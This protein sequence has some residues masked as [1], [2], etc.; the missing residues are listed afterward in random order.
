[1]LKIVS[2]EVTTSDDLLKSPRDLMVLGCNPKLAIIVFLS[3]LLNV[4]LL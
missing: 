3:P 2:H 1:M 4:N